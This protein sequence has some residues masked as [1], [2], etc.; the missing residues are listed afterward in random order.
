M[1]GAS[2]NIKYKIDVDADADKHETADNANANAVEDDANE[3]DDYDNA[4][5]NYDNVALFKRYIDKDSKDYD[6]ETEQEYV[7][8]YI[9]DSSFLPKRLRDIF[10]FSEKHGT[11][12]VWSNDYQSRTNN[13]DNKFILA[14][15]NVGG[16]EDYFMFEPHTGSDKSLLVDNVSR[17]TSYTVV[18]FE[19]G[20]KMYVVTHS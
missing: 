9:C 17:Q 20:S 2:N 3:E 19:N 5:I 8:Q 15:F 12:L 13:I 1:Y 18:N 4:F 7:G 14:F 6:S 16:D 11:M 10:E